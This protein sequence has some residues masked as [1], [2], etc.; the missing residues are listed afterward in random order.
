MIDLSYLNKITLFYILKIIR[1]LGFL[2]VFV[3]N[4]IFFQVFVAITVKLLVFLGYQIFW[5]P[6][7]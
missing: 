5:Q 6:W 3:Q 4:S 7:D 2:I 1:I